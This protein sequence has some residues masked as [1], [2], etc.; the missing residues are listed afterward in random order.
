M[1]SK[2]QYELKAVE[3]RF[4][5][6]IAGFSTVCE[7]LMVSSINNLNGVCYKQ[8]LRGLQNDMRNDLETYYIHIQR[9]ENIYVAMISGLR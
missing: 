6:I 3:A 5:I 8:V 7:R 4:D 1:T 2:A 9:E